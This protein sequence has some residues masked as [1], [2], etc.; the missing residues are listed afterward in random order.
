MITIDGVEYAEEDL[1]EEAKI[2][3]NRILDLRKEIDR[4]MLNYDEVQA[5]ISNHEL[6]VK[7]TLDVPVQPDQTND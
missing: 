6:K 4:L 3:I 5:A 7:A 1:S 2:R